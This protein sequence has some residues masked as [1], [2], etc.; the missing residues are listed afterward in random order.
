MSLT[1]SLSA[2]FINQGS[3]VLPKTVAAR[4]QAVRAQLIDA[5]TDSLMQSSRTNMRKV[6]S[7]G[8]HVYI[9]SGSMYST[10]LILRN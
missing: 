6:I 3:L 9:T 7:T 8:T 10:G 5:V 4:Y 1:F 2:I